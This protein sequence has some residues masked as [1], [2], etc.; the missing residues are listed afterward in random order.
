MRILDVWTTTSGMLTTFHACPADA[1]GDTLSGGYHDVLRR[2]EAVYGAPEYI[3][4]NGELI[5]WA[6]RFI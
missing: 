3:R 2:A 4:R 6:R 5:Q 1:A